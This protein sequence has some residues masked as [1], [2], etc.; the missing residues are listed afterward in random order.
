MSVRAV[1]ERGQTKSWIGNDWYIGMYDESKHTQAYG[2]AV[3]TSGGEGNV[4]T[5]SWLPEGSNTVF[6]KVPTGKRLIIT[7]VMLNP[8]GDVRAAHTRES[9]REEPG[10][11]PPDLLPVSRSSWRSRRSS[12]PSIHC[13]ATGAFSHRPCHL[14]W[15]RGDHIHRRKAS[16]RPAHQRGTER[17]P[18]DVAGR[19]FRSSFAVV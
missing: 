16:G 4:A 8:Q 19:M 3:A 17:L 2:Y 13:H 15:Q 6:T 7:D 5:V 12:A 14:G 1:R 10:R 9:G 18:R 11:N